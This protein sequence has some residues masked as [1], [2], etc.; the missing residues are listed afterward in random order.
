[1]TFWIACGAVLGLALVDAFVLHRRRGG[2]MSP[3]ALRD[4]PDAAAEV[5]ANSPQMNSGQS[6]F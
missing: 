6:S 5:Q 2:R 4:H 3:D 1:M